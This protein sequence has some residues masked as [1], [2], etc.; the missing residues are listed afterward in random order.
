[1][2]VQ[3][4]IEGFTETENEFLRTLP[5]WWF[6]QVE[7]D[8]GFTVEISH[9]DYGWGWSAVVEDIKNF[10]D[11][12]Q[13]VEVIVENYDACTETY[14]RLDSSGHGD[15]SV[16]DYIG[17]VLNGFE[18]LDECLQAL[19]GDLFEFLEYEEESSDSY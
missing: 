6:C 4:S 19:S 17:T 11:F 18:T 7:N 16:P 8:N 3:Y 14:L 13:K 1:M 9:C 12:C 2:L 5:K 15:G 10:K